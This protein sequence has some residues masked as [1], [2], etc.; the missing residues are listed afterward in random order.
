MQTS[1]DISVSSARNAEKNNIYINQGDKPSRFM[2]NLNF[3]EPVEEIKEKIPFFKN[4][5]NKI[6]EY[7]KNYFRNEE[8][9]A[10]TKIEY[11]NQGKWWEIYIEKIK[12]HYQKLQLKTKRLA[13]YPIIK[14]FISLLSLVFNFIYKISYGFGWTAVFV[15]KFIFISI[16]N[17][18]KLIVNF[19][20]SWQSNYKNFTKEKEAGK[21]D[22]AD[23]KISE[24]KEPGLP[25]ELSREINSSIGKSG[26]SAKRQ[27][28]K[29][30]IPSFNLSTLK[31]AVCFAVFLLILILPVKGLLYYKKLSSLKSYVMGVSEAAVIDMA[32]AA[33]SASDLNFTK[34]QELFIKAGENFS[35]AKN[36]IGSISGF[37][38]ILSSIIPNK[39]LKMAS[40]AD[41]ILEA[42]TLSAEIGRHLSSPLSILNSNDIKIGNLIDD[43]YSEG[44]NA[45][46]KAKI[47]ISTI[48]KINPDNLPNEYK[49]EFIGLKEKSRAILALLTEFEDVLASA[50]L[51]LGFENDKR[52]LLVFQNNAE[53]RASGGFIGSFAIIDFR[54]GEIKNIE[55][56]SGGSYDTEGGLFERIIAPEPFH[57]INPLWHFWDANWWPD[58]PKSA[59]KLMWFYEKSGGS[60]VDGVISL[61]PTAIEDILRIIGPVYIDSEFQ[62]LNGSMEI[63]SDNFWE[64]TQTFSE[65]KPLDHPGYFQ[66]PY[67]SASSTNASSTNENEPN[68][69][70]KKIIGC[71][72]DKIIEKISN[73]KDKDSLFSLVK[74]IE[75]NFIKK[76]ILMYFTDEE[77]QASAVKYGFDGGIKETSRDYLMVVN[78]NIGG[79]KS[80]RKIKEEITHEAQVDENGAII[81]TVTIKRVHT[82]QSDELFT[83][84]RNIDW[85]RTYV[86]L[87]SELISAQGFLPPLERQFEKPE[88]DWDVDPDIFKNEDQAITE[89]NSGTKIYS[90]FNKTVF[91]NWSQIDP[92]E[93]A[94]IK[95]KYR[96]PFELKAESMDNFKTKLDNFFNPGIKDLVPYA[97]YAQKQPGSIGSVFTSSL[98][99]P[100]NY[101]IVWQYG[102]NIETTDYAWSTSDILD[103]DK[104]WAVIMQVD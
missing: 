94:T 86:P 47:L 58:W 30:I 87:G 78:T 68:V 96:L 35:A 44:I 21:E 70:P 75:D 34:A 100:N 91:A 84:A 66:N 64:I 37:L 17:L 12:N 33:N 15:L 32:S 80:D 8:D 85:M 93:T 99:M 36:E 102:E 38:Q 50:R 6:I 77:L 42:G 24:A 76:H 16:I 51:F 55:V 26:I 65:Q 101:K 1:K 54:N 72:M 57:L 103:M 67:I 45:C 98:K 79:A 104:Y 59:E 95:I 27:N 25:A 10:I 61:T 5:K 41:L 3:L 20:L 46:S 28:F 39:E 29:K 74:I 73:N 62:L 7:V 43:F 60:T 40:E 13:I 22:V 19:S 31:A 18:F 48:D 97:L 81:N 49:K 14:I 56:P 92:G 71:L 88:E 53:M 52:Y 11:T 69:A 90:E 63:N 4:L 9:P 23:I 2:V 89:I 83:G 82:G